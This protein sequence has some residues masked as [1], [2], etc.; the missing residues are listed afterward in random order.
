MQVN[1]QV[2]NEQPNTGTDDAHLED[3]SNIFLAD[4]IEYHVNQFILRVND[5][6]GPG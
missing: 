2:D 1:N 4:V 5:D 3:D 6:H